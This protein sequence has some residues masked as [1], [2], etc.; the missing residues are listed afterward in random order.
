MDKK[1]SQQAGT[2]LDP[3]CWSSTSTLHG[4]ACIAAG[5]PELKDPDLGL[6]AGQAEADLGSQKHSQ[7]P[8]IVVQGGDGSTT[9]SLQLW[10]PVLQQAAAAKF[11]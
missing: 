5:T 11:E 1:A 6:G 3:V 2:G 4:F 8:P 7:K 10:E 9:D